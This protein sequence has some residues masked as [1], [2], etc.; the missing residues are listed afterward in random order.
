M[1]PNINLPVSVAARD[2]FELNRE[3]DVY[4]RRLIS[5]WIVFQYSVCQT[6]FIWPRYICTP[7]RDEISNGGVKKMRE[8]S[9]EE[10]AS[11]AGGHFTVPL[12]TQILYGPPLIDP[13][14]LPPPELPPDTITFC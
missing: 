5:L 8:L 11:I 7:L 14:D 3:K 9:A 4:A 1:N 13:P 12:R 6:S 10:T 2:S